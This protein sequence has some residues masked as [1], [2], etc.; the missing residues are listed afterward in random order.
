M[1][2]YTL[3]VTLHVVEKV[4]PFHNLKEIWKEQKSCHWVPLDRKSRMAVWE[5]ENTN[6]LEAYA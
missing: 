4:A 6:M 5:K 2:E 3:E 1:C